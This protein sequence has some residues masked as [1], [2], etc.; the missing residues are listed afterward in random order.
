MIEVGAATSATM[1]DDEFS[2]IS[3]NP[4]PILNLVIRTLGKILSV[5]KREDNLCIT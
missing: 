5:K 1:S 4:A 3:P 2:K